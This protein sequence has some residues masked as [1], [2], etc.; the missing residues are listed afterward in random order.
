MKMIRLSR[1]V[2]RAI[3]TGLYILHNFP[4]FPGSNNKIHTTA[5]VIFVD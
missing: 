2:F 3:S 5:R 4:A 1:I